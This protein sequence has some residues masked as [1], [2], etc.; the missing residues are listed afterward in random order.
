MVLPAHRPFRSG[1]GL[2]TVCDIRTSSPVL[3][4]R[5]RELSAL[6]E[7]VAERPS[8][9]LLEGEAG[10]G[11]TRLV[12]ELLNRPGIA[13][14]RVLTGACQPLREPFPYGPVLEALGGVADIPLGPLSPVV[15]VLRPLLPEIAGLLPEQPEPLPDKAAERHREFRAVRELLAAC[16][17]VLLVIDDLHWADEHTRDLLWFVLA[18]PPRDLGVV[19][20]YRSEDLGTRGPLGMPY[21]PAEGVRAARIQLGPLDVPAVRELASAILD[22]PRV[23]EDFAARLHEA[24]GGIPFVIEETLRALR[25]P[26]GAVEAGHRLLDTL[27]VPVLLREAMTE[28]MSSLNGAAVRVARAAAVLGVPATT[29]LLGALSGLRGRPLATALD[30]ALCCGV[31]RETAP[32][33]F[34]FRH[35]LARKAGY[36]AVSGPER[37][38]LHARA[39]RA[40]AELSPAPLI[41]LAGHARAAGRTAEWRRYAEAAA[42]QAVELGE[43]SLAID[44]LQAVLDEGAPGDEDAGRMAVTLSQVALR[45]LRTEVTR[46]LEDVLGRTGLEPVVRGTIRMNTGLLLVRKDGELTRGRAEVERAVGEL[47]DR[48]GLAARGINLLAQPLDGTTPL[49][50]HRRWMTRAR[51]VY[52]LLDDQELRLALTADRVASR[53]HI[54]D[55]SAWA[56][57][58]AFDEPA[59]TAGE[60]VQLAR[61]LC[62]VADA[63]AWA[64]HLGRSGEI[65]KEGLRVATTAGALFVAGNGQSTRVRLDWLTGNWTGLAESA[66][67]LREKYHDLM[68]ITSESALVLGGLAAVRGEFGAA[69]RYLATTK[70]S[71]PGEGVLPVVLGA[72]ATL[73]SIRLENGDTDGAR[74][75]VDGALAAARLKAVWVWAAELIPVAVETYTR[76]RRREDAV[77]AL[78]E[79]RAGVA[80]R[81]A[82]VTAAALAA[83]EAV[84]SAAGGEHADAAVRFDLAH[85]LYRELPMPYRATWARER[86]AL[87]RLATGDAGAVTGLAEAAEEYERLGAIRDAGR[88]RNGLRE[89]GA[90]VPS[91]RGRRGY[92]KR[93]SP[94]EAEIAAMLA[95]G[96]T[97][98]EIA[99]GL[100]LSPRTVE[101]HVANVL[102]KLGARSRTEV[103]HLSGRPGDRALITYT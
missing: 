39:M 18:R 98:R 82:P 69:E 94:R 83:A 79:F 92:G 76:A 87:S 48:P 17:P 31:L 28:R 44:T 96:R 41:Q 86:A 7:L 58:D 4:G 80:G 3:V 24:G 46:T 35:P 9:V 51:E 1:S 77:H 14:G 16:G 62:N 52:E 47:A 30:Q 55:G 90:W 34:G 8:A 57:F 10:M 89:H 13:G 11:K 64:G 49:A 19:V 43:T 20:T 40:L 27:E 75:I 36:D 38:L 68:S 99:A 74:T 45:G 37:S 81:D 67:A 50:W 29:G 12:Q 97:N 15:G 103:A 71:V 100:F 42:G 54:G 53:V 72:A 93:L 95:A 70:V 25:G 32:G 101:Q 63:G 33:R 88:C 84:L 2:P 56:E 22:A 61:F 78:R 60:R 73:A 66:A 6:A 26:A 91:G 21:R 102:R 23:A 59:V 85:A 65:L 5:D